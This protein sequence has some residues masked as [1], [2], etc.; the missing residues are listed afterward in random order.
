[1]ATARRFCQ[2]CRLQR[3]HLKHPE[4]KTKACSEALLD[5]SKKIFLAWHHCEEM[6]EASFHRSMITHRRSF[7]RNHF[8]E[9]VRKP[10]DSTEAGK[11]TTQETTSQEPFVCLDNVGQRGCPAIA[12]FPPLPK[13]QA[14]RP[15]LTPP[16]IL[17]PKWQRPDIAKNTLIPYCKRTCGIG[18]LWRAGCI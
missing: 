5:R 18:F 16:S 2:R 13:W 12:A 17:R 14:L 6:T 15:L 8:L 3:F 1:M 11:P 10:P 9:I 4:K 7:F